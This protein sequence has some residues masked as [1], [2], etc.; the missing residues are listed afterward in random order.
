MI[1]EPRGDG[2]AVAAVVGAVGCVGLVFI[3]SPAPDTLGFQQSTRSLQ[4]P[5]CRQQITRGRN[6]LMIA[7][8]VAVKWPRGSHSV[9]LGGI[10]GGQ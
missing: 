2:D 1:G 9:G 10:I 8:T 7:V 6:G 3:S 4:Q 5:G